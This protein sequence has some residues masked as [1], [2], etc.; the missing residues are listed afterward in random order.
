VSV[1]VFGIMVGVFGDYGR[2]FSVVF[3][4]IVLNNKTMVVLSVGVSVLF[5]YR[6]PTFES[7]FSIPAK[8][9]HF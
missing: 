8:Q 2:C 1:G 6:L 9:Y 7:D 5:R 4:P 3:P